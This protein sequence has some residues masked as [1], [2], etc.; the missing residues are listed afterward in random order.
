MV[1]S[2]G[3]LI[4]VDGSRWNGVGHTRFLRAI[5]I[6][7]PDHF[8]NIYYITANG[9]FINWNY[10]DQNGICYFS[11]Y[12]QGSLSRC[13]RNGTKFS[14][15]ENIGSALNF[16]NP[17]DMRG[18]NNVTSYVWKSEFLQTDGTVNA[19]SVLDYMFKRCWISGEK[20]FKLTYFENLSNSNCSVLSSSLTNE[21]AIK[22]IDSDQSRMQ[23]FCHYLGNYWNTN[24][25]CAEALKNIIFKKGTNESAYR[26]I[27]DDETKISHYWRENDFY[28][29]NSEG[30]W[31][32]YSY[33]GNGNNAFYVVHVVDS[34]GYPVWEA[35]K[36]DLPSG[37]MTTSQVINNTIYMSYSLLT[38]S[39]AET[40]YHQIYSV[41]LDTGAYKNLFQNVPNNSNLEVISY[42]VG[43][44]KLY[45]SAVRGTVVENGVVDVTTGEYSPLSTKK[46]LTAIYTF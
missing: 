10:D 33:N 30:L 31:M 21:D 37:K 14:D 28:F 35:S 8:T 29:S 40:G 24:I 12:E 34:K 4:I 16:L 45:Y 6:S 39:G 22:W 20:E 36:K 43:S 26:S 17:I 11:D 42:S 3:Q 2:D 38:S 5:P 13:I 7:D 25:G 15:A 18:S 46:K 19:K 41:N 44:N 9:N 27:S 23:W 32:N 1:T